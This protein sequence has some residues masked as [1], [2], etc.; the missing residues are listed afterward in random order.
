MFSPSF[1]SVQGPSHRQQLQ[2]ARELRKGSHFYCAEVPRATSVEEAKGRLYQVGS[3]TCAEIALPRMD[4]GGTSGKIEWTSWFVLFLSPKFPWL[5]CM[6]SPS[7]SAGKQWE[8]TSA[9]MEKNRLQVWRCSS[10]F[11]GALLNLVRKNWGTCLSNM[12]WNMRRN[13]KLP[14]NPKQ[15]ANQRLII[16]KWFGVVVC[17]SSQRYCHNREA[18]QIPNNQTKPKFGAEWTKTRANIK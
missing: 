2:G 7:E 14:I 13:C 9:A 1:P 12:V 8:T 4:F 16:D 17:K 18:T 15:H 5:S 6:S 3:V 10:A 11:R